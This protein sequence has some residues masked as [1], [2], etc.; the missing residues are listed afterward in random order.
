MNRLSNKLLFSIVSLLLGSNLYAQD[1]SQ[2]IPQIKDAIVTIHAQDVN[3]ETFA[4]GSGF[5][6]SSNGIGVTNFHV[7]QGASYG[8][9]ICTN[10]QEYAIESIIDYSP[11][12]DLVK[13]K[14]K[15]PEIIFHM[16][17]GGCFRCSEG[18][19]LLEGSAGIYCG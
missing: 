9:V 8:S 4:S 10:G 1:V 15:N 18:P 19:S 6:I 7:L 5:F 3:H 13:F 17:P 14:I 16:L 2:L 12:F 11:K